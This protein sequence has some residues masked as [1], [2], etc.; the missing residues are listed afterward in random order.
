MGLI[1]KTHVSEPKSSI[2]ELRPTEAGKCGKHGG[3][4][5]SARARLRRCRR[6]ITPRITHD[7]Y[8]VLVP[9]LQKLVG[10]CQT[11]PSANRMKYPALLPARLGASSP[12]AT[13]PA[14]APEPYPSHAA[15]GIGPRLLVMAL[16]AESI[17]LLRLVEVK[18]SA[19]GEHRKAFAAMETP[20][21]ASHSSVG[22]GGDFDGTGRE[23]LVGT[24]SVGASARVST[25]TSST[26]T[27]A[28]EILPSLA[29]RAD[30]VA[31]P[32]MKGEMC[33]RQT[34]S[35][36]PSLNTIIAY[37]EILWSNVRAGARL[38]A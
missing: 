35:S 7:S 29:T 26:C 16:A 17:E 5:T 12:I 37:C 21:S 23:F 28:D 15:G 25:T 30:P 36:H 24:R 1:I 4:P 18:D 14:P 22:T 11:R 34:I 31:A 38:S 20:V 19:F 8:P 9:N 33:A 27:E 2:D 6:S 3:G 10:G 13:A 32:S